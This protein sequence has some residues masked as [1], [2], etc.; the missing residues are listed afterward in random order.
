MRVSFFFRSPDVYN[1]LQIFLNRQF[2]KR[3]APWYMG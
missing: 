2:H 1:P 3:L